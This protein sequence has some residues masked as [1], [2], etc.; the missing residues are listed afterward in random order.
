MTMA[1][2]RSNGA[3]E[4]GA[5]PAHD[6]GAIPAGSD[7]RVLIV[8]DNAEYRDLFGELATRSHCT[9]VLA[10]SLKAARRLVSDQTFDL[11]V[12]DLN[13]PDGNGLD[14]IDDIDIAE[15]GQIAVVTGNPSVETAIRAVRGPVVDYLVKPVEPEILNELLKRAH[16]HARIR[17]R[18]GST[19]A[20]GEML[21]DSPVMKQLF[22]RIQRVA[23]LDVT[24]L[25]FGESGTGKELAARALHQLSGRTGPFV[26]VNCGA[27]AAD[28]LTS[29]LYGHERGAFT[30]A[31]NSHQGYFEQ[32]EG[33]TLFLDEVAEMPL[34]LQVYLLRVLESRKVTR[35]GGSKEIP[36][37][38]RVI[39]ATNRDPERAVDAGQLRPDLYYRLLDF[40]L[41]LPPLRERVSDIPLLAEHFL[42][43]L[44]DRYGTRRRFGRG[45]LDKLMA[46][47]WPGNVRELKHSIQQAY[48]VSVGEDVTVP[49]RGRSA[50]PQDGDGTVRF[51]V[52]MSL[53]EIEREM[54][55]RT[56]AHYGNNKRRAARALGITA[57][58]IYNRLAQYRQ[59]GITLPPGLERLDA[60]G[61]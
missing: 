56:L 47:S 18:L 34:Q 57:K 31:L 53:E 30:G 42:E 23:P 52:G 43:R 40:P 12:L 59:Q 6:A 45:E 4:R 36:V 15:N 8:D 21:G 22:E 20:L 5:R 49:L 26:A 61:A 60:D 19:G 39:A 11:I 50:R 28:L 46:E 1:A 37:D 9:P 14:L 2:Q 33:G 24:A 32:A 55:F 35:I 54:L 13:L 10:D 7:A 38:V 16:A 51:Q 58:T 25:I 44:N 41:R 17:H 29:H 48:I 27:V 3:Y